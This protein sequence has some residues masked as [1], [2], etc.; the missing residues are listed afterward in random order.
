VDDGF[1]YLVT[2]ENRLSE[3]GT[4]GFDSGG[5]ERTGSACP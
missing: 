2:V 5:G 3:E 4:K 1:F